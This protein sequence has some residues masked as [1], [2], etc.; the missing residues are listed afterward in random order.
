MQKPLFSNGWMR[1][2]SFASRFGTI[3][4]RPINVH[5][6]WEG[7]FRPCE[8][9]K[10]DTWGGLDWNV[11][12]ASIQ[13]TGMPAPTG[14][15]AGAWFPNHRLASDWL[16]FIREQKHPADSFPDGKDALHSTFASPMRQP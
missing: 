7:F 11:C 8:N 16:A 12:D 15:L 4:L 2:E 14:R 13:P 10:R 3:P 5:Q 1:S 6:G 9:G